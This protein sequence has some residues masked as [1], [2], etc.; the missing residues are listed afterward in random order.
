MLKDINYDNRNYDKIENKTA[1]RM[2]IVLYH[3]VVR[4][5]LEWRIYLVA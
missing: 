3:K 2:H 5:R 4:K 1:D